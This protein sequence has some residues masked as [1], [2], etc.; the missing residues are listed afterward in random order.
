MCFICHE[1]TD[2]TFRVVFGTSPIAAISRSSCLNLN[3]IESVRVIG[4]M[5][6]KN[7]TAP[8]FLII[9]SHLI[10][11]FLLVVDTGEQVIPKSLQLIAG[12]IAQEYNIRKKRKGVRSGKTGI[13]LLLFR[14]MNN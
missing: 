11:L 5:R 9:S 14:P 12:R 10:I 3:K 7:E 8:V 1:P 6:Q 13:M 2:I 4:F